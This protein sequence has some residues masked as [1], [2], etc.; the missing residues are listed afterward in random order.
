VPL[1]AAVD[2]PAGSD[3]EGG[4]QR[5]RPMALV[6]M[7]PP[8]D[9]PRPQRQQ[10]LGT[11]EPLD[12]RLFIDAQHQSMVGRVEVKPDDVADLVD[13]QR[14]VGQLEGFKAV[15]LQPENAPDTPDA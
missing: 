1:V 7:C 6:V 3:V 8:L 14:I 15:R 5:G 13:K 4:E 12:L 11:V 9:L 2:D 10:R